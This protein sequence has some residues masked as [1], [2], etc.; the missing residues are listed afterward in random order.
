[1]NKQHLETLDLSDLKAE[2]V[3][4]GLQPQKTKAQSIRVLMAHLQDNAPLNLLNLENQDEPL[5]SG[6]SPSISSEDSNISCI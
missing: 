6:V 2:L 1:M 3:K 4:Y 5:P